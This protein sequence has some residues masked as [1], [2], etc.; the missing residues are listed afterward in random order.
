VTVTL[1]QLLYVEDLPAVLRSK[2]PNE[3]FFFLVGV[4]GGEYCWFEVRY[5]ILGDVLKGLHCV[6]PNE[7]ASV[8]ERLAEVGSV[9][10]E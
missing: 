5:Y 8:L 2:P 1:D 6:N 3:L 9:L 10:H 7:V 4:V